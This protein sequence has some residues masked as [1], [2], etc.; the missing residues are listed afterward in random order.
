MSLDDELYRVPQELKVQI[1]YELFCITPNLSGHD[2]Y[3]YVCGLVYRIG[4]RE[5]NRSKRWQ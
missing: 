4:F 1:L 2:V 3:V 5:K